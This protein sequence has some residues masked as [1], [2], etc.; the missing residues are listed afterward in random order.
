MGM[1]VAKKG[2]NKVI[3]VEQAYFKMPSLLLV[4]LACTCRLVM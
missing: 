4:A 2:R 1:T 3:V